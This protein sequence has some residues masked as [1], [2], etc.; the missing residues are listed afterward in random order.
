[1]APADSAPLH[2]PPGPT[3]ANDGGWLLAGRYRL[4]TLLGRGGMGEVWAATDMALK[5]EVA[6]KLTQLRLAD[7][8]DFARAFV[9]ETELAARLIHP[10]IPHIYTT[11]TAPDGRLFMVMEL[12]QGITLRR[13]M[14]LLGKVPPVR[15]ICYATFAAEALE[16]AHEA[17]V[18]HR[19]VK[20][21]N[22]MV[23]EGEEPRAWL[24][25][26]GIAKRLLVDDGPL[27]E[28]GTTED[29]PVRKSGKRRSTVLGTV[30]YVPPEAGLGGLADHRGDLFQLGVS[31]YEAISGRKPFPV[32]E[33]DKTGT[34]C[35]LLY[36]DPPPLPESECPAGLWSILERLLAKAPEDRYGS[37]GELLT[38]LVALL[39]EFRESV[40]AG[41]L[42]VQVLKKDRQERVVR[43]A[44]ASVAP[45]SE[46]PASASIGAPVATVAQGGTEPIAGRPT[47]TLGSAF[48]AKSPA[49]RGGESKGDADAGPR[50]TTPM[51]PGVVGV[52]PAHPEAARRARERREEPQAG[53]TGPLPVAAM[54]EP[55]EEITARVGRAWVEGPGLTALPV[56]TTRAEPPRAAG[57]V[58]PAPSVEEAPA[59]ASTAW[60]PSPMTAAL[61]L[62]AVAIGVL[63]IAIGM[64]VGVR[65][66]VPV[67]T[68]SVVPVATASVVPVVTASAAPVATTSVVP[69]ATVSAAP[70][71]TASA[72]P[73]KAAV[74]PMPVVKRSPEIVDPFRDGAKKQAKPG[75]VF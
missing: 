32:Y 19:D 2:L 15:M 4:E 65:S 21:E 20:P 9:Q 17:G 56:P 22:L 27:A 62:A 14:D 30:G 60:R 13:L 25:D 39:Q 16:Y 36:E 48:V 35:A 43:Q 70:V 26:F 64:M 24:L 28:G 12:I 23:G 18:C 47:L 49:F 63:G 5:R 41:A 34:L 11:E 44:F 52:S 8:P 42:R 1:M 55:P 40:P 33:D 38:A 59:R 37:A 10:N 67:A 68:A 7:H 46:P 50:P 29:E 57:E 71:A 73:A 51:P 69:V 75:W 74:K 3:P 31:M 72:A 45:R 53:A 54:E 66:V 61:V 6:V 58:V